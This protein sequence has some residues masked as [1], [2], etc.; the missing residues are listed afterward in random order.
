MPRL[1][2]TLEV[3]HK[4]LPQGSFDTINAFYELL[5]DYEALIIDETFPRLLR[6]H[7]LESWHTIYDTLDDLLQTPYDE[8]TLEERPKRDDFNAWV[9][10]IKERRE[11]EEQ[12]EAEYAERFGL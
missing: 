12:S 10:L 8:V 9:L 3:L 5:D 11:R 1:Q 7:I 4:A 6:E 2:R